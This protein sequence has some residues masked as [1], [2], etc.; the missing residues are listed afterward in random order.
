MKTKL[1]PAAAA[2]L[3]AAAFAAPAQ[4]PQAPAATPQGTNA[5]QETNAKVVAVPAP[6]KNFPEVLFDREL[7]GLDGRSLFLSTFKGQVFVINL[8]ASW[9]GPCRVEAPELNK[10]HD[11]YAARGVTLV[12]LTVEDPKTDAGKVR[13]FVEGL[14]VKYAVGW[15]DHDTARLLMDGRS[16]LPQTI[17]VGPDSR[18]LL[19]QVGYSPKQSPTL[20]RE[21]IGRALGDGQ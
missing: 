3:L 5:K 2:C 21:A 12:G 7:K 4:T 15:A 11:E 18:I 10:I 20:L 17:V 13:E 16:N 19:R 14:G 6:V 9:C 8:W 1:T